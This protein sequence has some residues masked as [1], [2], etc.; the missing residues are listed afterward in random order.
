MW[1]FVGN[2]SWAEPP[3]LNVS[4]QIPSKEQSRTW[5]SVEM[6]ELAVSAVLS[7]RRGAPSGGA[8]TR[9]PSHWLEW[10]RRGGR[11]TRQRKATFYPNPLWVLEID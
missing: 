2:P 3:G 4:S 5:I 9:E 7:I 10:G 1:E 8:G 11:D 6:G